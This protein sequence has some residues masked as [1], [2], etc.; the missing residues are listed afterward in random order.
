[1]TKLPRRV[2]RSGRLIQKAKNKTIDKKFRVIANG[3]NGD[4]WTHGE[5]ATFDEARR[6]VDTLPNSQVDYLIYSDKNRVLYTKE[7]DKDGEF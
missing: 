2:R 4:F 5:Y 6:E 7:N 1:M 3:H